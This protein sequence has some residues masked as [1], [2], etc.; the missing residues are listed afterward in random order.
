M[1]SV[2]DMPMVQD[3]PPPGGFPSVRYGRRIPNT[4]PTGTA[5]FGITAVVMAYGFYKVGQTNHERRALKYEKLSARQ[6]LVPVLQAEEDRRWMVQHQKNI[7]FE[8]KIMKD[9]PG[10]KA[11]EPVYNTKRWMPAAK[12]VGV[13]GSYNNYG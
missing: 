6:A 8:A 9:V 11:G 3:G 12:P 13:W 2:K 1:K 5:L 10:W 4:G 7:E